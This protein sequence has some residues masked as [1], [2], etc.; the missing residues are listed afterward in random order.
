MYHVRILWLPK[1]Y[2]T[3]NTETTII[4]KLIHVMFDDKLGSE[5][6]KL[7]ENFVYLKDSFLD[8]E[9]KESEERD[10]EKCWMKKYS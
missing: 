9:G 8:Y 1:G 5:K 3:S 7:F 4:V 10:S 2:W 6:S